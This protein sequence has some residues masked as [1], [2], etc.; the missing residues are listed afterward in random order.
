MCHDDKYTR[1][2]GYTLKSIHILAKQDTELSNI[3][4]TSL[5]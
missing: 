1:K 5:K 3:M 2:T 4:V